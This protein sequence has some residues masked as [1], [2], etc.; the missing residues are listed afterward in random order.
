MSPDAQA[1]KDTDLELN[2]GKINEYETEPRTRYNV[3]MCLYD[4]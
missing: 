3:V 2:V 4:K 1:H